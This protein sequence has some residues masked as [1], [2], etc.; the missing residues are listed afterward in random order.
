MEGEVLQMEEDGEELGGKQPSHLKP[1]AVL[2]H[3]G[4]EEKARGDG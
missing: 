1:L 2:L 4:N 3:S